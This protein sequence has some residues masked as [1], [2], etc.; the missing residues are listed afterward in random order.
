MSTNLPV[1]FEWREE[2]LCGVLGWVRG[3]G[4]RK[5]AQMDLLAKAMAEARE[6]EA[7]ETFLREGA[8]G[9][10]FQVP[11]ECRRPR[12]IP[13]GDRGFDLPGPMF[14][15]VRDLAGIVFIQ[16]AREIIG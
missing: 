5:G 14:G 10:G 1:K 12:P 15:G 16:A 11:L 8:A 4:A 13:K 3:D 6:G 7:L 9:G 2:W